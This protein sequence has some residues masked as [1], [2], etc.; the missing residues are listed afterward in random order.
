VRE[1]DRRLAATLAEHGERR[2][3]R[4]HRAAAAERAGVVD[5]PAERMPRR[6]HVP[7]VVEARRADQAFAAVAGD[8]A[9]KG[10]AV[11]AF[12]VAAEVHRAVRVLRARV[13]GDARHRVR[14]EAGPIAGRDVI[15]PA[16][17]ARVGE[18]GD[19]PVGDLQSVE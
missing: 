9:F 15:L 1:E 16:V 12:V 14:V 4:C 11:G 2:F 13:F 6:A 10:F 18:L 5:A 8:R 7:F 17:R 19:D 3:V